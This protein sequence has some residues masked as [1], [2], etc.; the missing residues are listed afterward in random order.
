MPING[1]N[2]EE[3]LSGYLDDMLDEHELVAVEALL[4]QQDSAGQDARDYL[5][6]IRQG[7]ELLVELREHRCS[8]P[9]ASGLSTDFTSQLLE[10]LGSTG[11]S[12]ETV[13]LSPANTLPEK[14]RSWQAVAAAV[15]VAA[16]CLALVVSLLP[17]GQVSDGD[18]VAKV[19]GA[20]PKTGSEEDED[21]EDN[22]KENIAPST[23]NLLAG[24]DSPEVPEQ[25]TGDTLYVSELQW[26]ISMVMVLHVRPTEA[27]LQNSVLEQI[28][29]DHG[30]GAVEPIV[31]TGEVKEAL[32]DSEYIV[33][34]DVSRRSGLYF[35]RA[36][37]NA[38]DGAFQQIF[39][40]AENFPDARYNFAIDNPQTRLMEKVARSTGKRFA[41]SE[42]FA[43]PV[44]LSEEGRISEEL[45]R[46]QAQERLVA[47]KERQPPVLAAMAPPGSQE[48]STVLILVELPE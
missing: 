24:N 45:P 6:S 23:G 4:G 30:I 11:Q 33:T 16:A 43:A 29:I 7:R 10:S 35:V 47:K 37:A 39:A 2:L 48:I 42:S 5:D 20:E 36:P 18:T 3:L 22:G 25:D 13:K 12:N 31:A 21:N 40:D 17:D 14:Q 28:L 19:D 32:Q 9:D 8:S 41:A 38:I 34:D 44:A 26:T 1:E 15:L 27:A 46:F